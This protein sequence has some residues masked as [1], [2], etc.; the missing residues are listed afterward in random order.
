MAFRIDNPWM[1]LGLIALAIPVLLHF[2]QRR[3]HDVVDWGAMQ[4]LPEQI[5]TQRRRWLDEILLMLLRMTMI[6]LVVLALATPFSTSPW[7]A[8]LGNASARDVVLVID[9]SYSMDVRSP[10]S[11]TPWEEA[12]AHARTLVENS[13]PGER[14]SVLIARQPPVFLREDFTVEPVETQAF[15]PRGNADMARSLAAAWKHLQTRSVASMKEIVVLTDGQRHGWADV[16]SLSALDHLGQ[17]W[18]SDAAAARLDG[19]VTP[20]LRVVKVG[21]EL[22]KS[23]PNYS[24]APVTASRGIAKIG[25]KIRFQ[26]ALHLA[27]FAEYRR[28]RPVRILVDGKDVQTLPLPE[29]VDLTRG[30][31]P[32]AF[33][34]R[35]ENEGLHRVT[36]RLD[37]EDAIPADNEQHVMV[38]VVKDLPLL[39]VEGSPKPSNEGSA[40]FIQRALSAQG[41]TPY[42]ALKPAEIAKSAVIILADVPHLNDAQ[43]EAI[44]RFVEAGGGLLVVVGDHVAR[45]K[46]FYNDRLYRKGT[47][48]LPAKLGDFAQ[49]K[50]GVQPDAKKF[51]HPALELFRSS[52][53]AV[54][55]V[56]FPRWIKGH[57][58]LRDRAT[59]IAAYTNGDAFLIEKP[60]GKGR[61]VLATTPMSRQWE[62]NF[63]NSWEFPVLLHNLVYHLAGVRAGETILNDGEPI[64]VSPPAIP[65]HV[66]LAS[67]EVRNQAFEVKT[68]PWIYENTGAVGSYEVRS[69][70]QLWPFFVAPDLRE[71]DLARCSADDWRRVGE[72]LSVAWQGESREP[73][74]FEEHQRRREDLWWVLLSVV[75]GFLCMELWMTRRM[76]MARGR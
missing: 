47:G 30:Q 43:I 19:K 63:T 68:T 42:V 17:Q 22:P 3:R 10:A 18:H 41:V 46:A 14:F 4:F 28:P 15:L 52:P 64:R 59:V 36:F 61:V 40:F 65:A 37:A 1:L 32:L 45:E 8:M 39:I 38:E 75:V 9:G 62:S 70:K 12:F 13:A 44:D 48:W 74:S 55:D 34:H 35:F 29:N 20:T 54:R 24:L 72:R 26:T 66:T 21:V 53:D 27:G 67:P 69:G 76:A 71:T 58:D 11:Q 50:N 56:R 51:Q 49:S 73:S 5:T 57:V 25:A 33:D 31:I 16:A 23:M 6:A 7:L 2:L 60:H